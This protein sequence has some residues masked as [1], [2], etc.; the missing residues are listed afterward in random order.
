[1][2]Q[3][4][5]GSRKFFRTFFC[6]LMLFSAQKNFALGTEKIVSEQ[7][8]ENSFQLFADGAAAGI[9]VSPNDW[10][11]VLRAAHDLQSDIAHVTDVMPLASWQT[12]VPGKNH[13]I[14]G[15]AGKSEIIDR[16]VRD[17]KISTT[18]IG[19]KWES[20]FIQTVEQPFPGVDN[21]LVI[22]GSDKRGTI[23]GVYELSEQMGVS[24]WYYWA[25]VPATHHDALFVK[26][27]KFLQG[28]P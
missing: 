25:D 13:I 10:P 26:A 5:A 3:L 4:R 21:A 23:Y 2:N 27:G 20:F 12:K 9:V 17:G 28:S 6:A 7:P 8:G 19:G 14:I 24:P 15:T 16:L 22:C 18:E 11:G 1:M